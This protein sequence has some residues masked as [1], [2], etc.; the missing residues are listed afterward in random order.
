MKE[1]QESGI[2]TRD[3]AGQPSK[4]GN[5]GEKASFEVQITCLFCIMLG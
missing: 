4:E 5:P 2:V 1:R 3:L